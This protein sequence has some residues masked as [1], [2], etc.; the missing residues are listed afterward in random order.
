MHP[1][2]LFSINALKNI[3]EH[4]YCVDKHCLS[5]GGSR[6]RACI[7]SRLAEHMKLRK[8]WGASE[9]DLKIETSLNKNDTEFDW[10]L[11]DKSLHS[12]DF[13]SN[14][15]LKHFSSRKQSYGLRYE[16]HAKLGKS[17]TL[18]LLK[19]HHRLLGSEKCL[20]LEKICKYE[21]LFSNLY[22]T[23]EKSSSGGIYR[24]FD[25]L[26]GAETICPEK[27]KI[28]QFLSLMFAFGH[29]GSEAY[30]GFPKSI[31]ELVA[32]YQF[33]NEFAKKALKSNPLSANLQA[34]YLN[35]T[36]PFVT[37]LWNYYSRVS[38]RLFSVDTSAILHNSN[39]VALYEQNDKPKLLGTGQQ[40]LHLRT[41]FKEAIHLNSTPSFNQT[42]QST[43]PFKSNF[44]ATY[45]PF[46]HSD[47][48]EEFF[49][50]SR[51]SIFKETLSDQDLFLYVR[52]SVSDYLH[53]IK[54]IISTGKVNSYPDQF[55]PGIIHKFQKKQVFDDIERSYLVIT[56]SYHSGVS[57]LLTCY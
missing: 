29:S 24:L 6:T 2:H 57:Y 35:S 30:D 43:V 46:K 13:H 53:M 22:T 21:G 8:D 27:F 45:H 28:R 7:N 47:A 38:S 19:S 10:D 32:K 41:A 4:R 25:L 23:C 39:V 49:G 20:S 14:D 18:E 3:N 17:F 15:I 1:E 26:E 55:T 33:F 56:R 11:L 5:K 16:I 34:G 44:E 36:I 52:D 37:K 9:S 50:R 31:G 51:A 12:S 40:V 48:S 42:L 54:D